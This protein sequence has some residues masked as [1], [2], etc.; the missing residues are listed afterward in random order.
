LFAFCS[1][2]FP[3]F[4]TTHSA[5]ANQDRRPFRAETASDPFIAGAR[6]VFASPQ[7][8]LHA[9]KSHRILMINMQPVLG[10]VLKRG[11][12]VG[13]KGFLCVLC[14]SFF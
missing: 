11:L 10:L 14:A 2:H 7:D 1:R 3:L 4:P 8:A 13:L 5:L 6:H 9:L 12:K